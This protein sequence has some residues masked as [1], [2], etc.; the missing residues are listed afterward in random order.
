MKEKGNK[1]MLKTRTIDSTIQ[2]EE[3]FDKQWELTKV[4]RENNNIEVIDWNKAKGAIICELWETANELK[5]EGFKEWTTKG[6]TAETL[7]EL[8]DV[9]FFYLQIGNDLGAVTEHHWIEKHPTIMEQILA[10]NTTMLSIDG[11]LSWTVSFAQYRGLVH[12]LGFN[13]KNDILPEYDRKY[14]KNVERQENGY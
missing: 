8:T 11:I 9:L 3:L 6:R 5:N 13:W 12:M 1:T 2:L 10:L 14:K 4:F 7:E